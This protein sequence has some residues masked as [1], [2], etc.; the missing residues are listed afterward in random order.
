MALSL[1][2]VYVEIII[3]H[4]TVLGGTVEAMTAKLFTQMK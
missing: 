3:Y 4:M 1:A 2:L